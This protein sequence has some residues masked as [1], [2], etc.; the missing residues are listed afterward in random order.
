MSLL[1]KSFLLVQKT[2]G[3]AVSFEEEKQ[4]SYLGLQRN[5][6]YECMDVFIFMSAI[7]GN[8]TV[9]SLIDHSCFYMSM[10]FRLN[11]DTPVE[12]S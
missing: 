8:L 5:S 11:A 4:F 6:M 3:F 1:C 2:L 12:F 7:L 10:N 9:N